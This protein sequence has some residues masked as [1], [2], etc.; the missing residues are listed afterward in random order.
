MSTQPSTSLTTPGDGPKFKPETAPPLSDPEL[1][2]AVSELN[3]QTFT[4]KFPKVDRNYADPPINLQTYG[5]VS[6]IP[7][8]GAT[9]NKRG[10]YGFAKLRG[11]FATEIESNQRAEMLIKECDSVHTIYHTYVGRPFPLTTSKDYASETSEVD[12]R[13]DTTESV[14]A[15]IKDQKAE[16]KK[17]AEEIKSR[18][19]ELMED[20]SGDRPQEDIDLDEYITLNVKKAQ[21]AW[22]YLEH[23]K[24]IKEIK[25]VMMNTRKAIVEADGVH[26]T[27]REMFFQKYTD[28]REKS[29]LTTSLE[30]D[31]K[32]DGFMRYLIEDVKLPGIDVADD[33]IDTLVNTEDPDRHEVTIVPT[34]LKEKQTKTYEDDV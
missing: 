14:S 13:K 34:V 9:P 15:A 23:I 2:D 26:P 11:N 12:I 19:R 33:L 27:F 18:E 24:K 31:A 21:L 7:A 17:K 5:L 25:G 1:V 28:A 22:T 32:R 6:F 4:N 8:K 16:D 30:E 29:G 20:V 3:V 10:I